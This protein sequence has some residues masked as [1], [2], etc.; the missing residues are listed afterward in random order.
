MEDL[1]HRHRPRRWAIRFHLIDAQVGRLFAAALVD[2]IADD[3]NVVPRRKLRGNQVEYLADFH[4]NITTN[5][6]LVGAAAKNFFAKET[7]ARRLV[8]DRGLD[9]VASDLTRGTIVAVAMSGCVALAT[10]VDTFHG[11]L[12]FVVQPFSVQ[13]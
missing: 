9:D 4:N 11:I 13:S 1:G 10:S 5:D 3:Y 2:A 12:P 7:L 8:D 6:Q